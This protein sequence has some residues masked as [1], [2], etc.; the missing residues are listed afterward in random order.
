MRQREQRPRG[1]HP[2]RQRA[3]TQTPHP[4][5]TGTASTIHRGSTALRH[6]EYDRTEPD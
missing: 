5:S 3:D 2:I 1:T 6:A 4:I